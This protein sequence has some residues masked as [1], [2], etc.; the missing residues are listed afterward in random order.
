MSN[1]AL[2]VGTVLRLGK[3]PGRCG[4]VLVVVGHCFLSIHPGS[5]HVDSSTLR[6]RNIDAG[7]SNAVILGNCA[8]DACTI[9]CQACTPA[10]QRET[11]CPLTNSRGIERS[12]LPERRCQMRDKNRFPSAQFSRRRRDNSGL[13]CPDAWTISR[14]RPC[15][16]LPTL[17]ASSRAARGHD[18]TSQRLA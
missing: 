6:D 12:D 4:S 3:H 16:M 2:G 11:Q 17:F 8:S 7:S 18:S 14:S 9:G 5:G 1:N 13:N 10:A 15:G